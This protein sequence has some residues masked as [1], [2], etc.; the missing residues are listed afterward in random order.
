MIELS[1]IMPT[2]RMSP[3]S[4]MMLMDMPKRNMKSKLTTKDMGMLK[5]I[6]RGD[7][8][9]FKKKNIITI[10]KKLP[11]SRLCFKLSIDSF[12]S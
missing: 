3:E 7:C 1:I 9:S 11:N 12:R 10:A 6:K 5:A 2:P 8:M 4:E